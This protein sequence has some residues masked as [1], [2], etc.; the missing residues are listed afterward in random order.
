MLVLVTRPVLF[1]CLELLLQN[2][3]EALRLT[4]SSKVRH[5]IAVSAEAGQNMISILS[6][7]QDQGLLEAFLPWDFDALFV[8]TT[9]LI[10]IRFING[11]LLSDKTQCLEKAFEEFEYMIACGNDVSRHRVRELRTLEGMLVGCKDAEVARASAR[12]TAGRQ[13]GICRTEGGRMDQRH[14]RTEP[15]IFAQFAD[16]NGDRNGSESSVTEGARRSKIEHVI[17]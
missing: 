10:S 9:V 4:T 12:A 13:L 16:P 17:C 8:S 2:P 5:L 6:S 14:G 11:A 1:C 15:Q 7:L 3:V